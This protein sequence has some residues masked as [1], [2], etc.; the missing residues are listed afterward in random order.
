M[1]SNAVLTP[2]RRD[3]LL[4]VVAVGLLAAPLWAPALNVGEPTHHYEGA[5]VATNGSDIEYVG[6]GDRPVGEPLSDRIACSPGGMVRPCGFE[7]LL[8]DGDTVPSGGY[9]NNANYTPWFA[10]PYDYVLLDDAVYEPTYET[11]ESVTNER[12]WYRI[13]MGLEP[14]PADDA[15]DDV[16]AD[17]DQV[18]SVVA[19]AA[20]NGEA[21]TREEVEAPETTIRLE[22]G[23]YYRVHRTGSTDAP[24]VV[25]LLGGSL[26]ALGP[27]AGVYLLVRV[28]RRV[29]VT[30]VG[31]K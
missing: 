3:A 6:S 22:D 5:E 29:E 14:A 10:N 26:W 4:V 31:S 20:R 25:R 16:S 27:L 28:S 18:P 19:E 15:L 2:L 24:P 13:E 8:A 23:S 11:N 12:G 17:A 1:P 7:Q 9:S 30:Y 21:S